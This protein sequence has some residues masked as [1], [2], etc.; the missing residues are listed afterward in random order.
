MGAPLLGLLKSIYYR[1]IGEDFMLGMLNFHRYFG[2]IVISKMLYRGSVPYI[3][4]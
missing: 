1:Y 4:L 3:L 2:D